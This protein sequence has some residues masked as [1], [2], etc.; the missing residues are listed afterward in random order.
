MKY[1]PIYHLSAFPG[2]DDKE[3]YAN[4]MK[5]LREHPG[6]A[7][8]VEPGVYRITDEVARQTQ[9]KVM[10]G[11]FGNYPQGTMFTPKFE[12]SVGIDFSGQQNTAVFG[13]GVTLEID[14]F[15][16]PIALQD[17]NGVTLNGITI[18]HRRKP[19]SRGRVHQTGKP[20]SD[21][22][23]PCIVEMDPDCPLSKGTPVT[24]RSLLWNETTNEIEN[25]GF[26]FEEIVDTY[27]IKAKIAGQESH[28]EGLQYYTM[29]TAHFRPA[30]LIERAQNITLQD[31]T[32]H[33][34]PGMGIVGNRSENVTLRRL[35]IV[36]VPGDHY[37]T[38][39]DGTHFTSIKGVLRYENCRLEGMG[40]D[41]VNVHCYYQA[42]VKR[43]GARVVYLQEKTPDGTHA[44]TL[45]YPD[46]G[47]VL[48]MSSIETMERL[49]TFRVIS[50]TPMPEEWMC[51]VELD[52]DAPEDTE[53]MIFADITRLP[54]LEVVG[55]TSTNHFAR[56]VLCKCRDALIEGNVFR[57]IMGPAIVLAAES[58]WYE[59]VCPANVTVRNNYIENCAFWW[60][61]ASG[62]V[63]KADAPH[64][65]KISIENICLE[66]N[67]IVSPNAD[68]GI[69]MRNTE[70][71]RITDN[72]V[73]CRNEPVEICC[74]QNVACD[75]NKKVD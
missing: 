52:K 38:N 51:R 16:E 70:N 9:E 41:F 39:T 73:I 27:H 3:I 48:E 43:E 40:D 12:Y 60:G 54:R 75:G 42:V 57:N 28:V 36:P 5:A 44:Q 32:I 53:K 71:S 30:I 62:V 67:F 1:N 64:A 33:N 56:G 10:R 11:D 13:Y 35:N 55:C 2:K 50:C 23:I 31:V 59:G 18:R 6:S 47:D 4:A 63:V 68:H 45:D 49:D 20:D 66:N 8:V 29:H 19:Y 21:G 7:L 72:T 58:Y 17:C 37:A 15:M 26:C 25:A 22:K 74:S 34:Q 24:M 14:G 61:E 46:V 65:D 69:F